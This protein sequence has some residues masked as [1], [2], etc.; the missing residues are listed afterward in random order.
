MKV[1]SIINTAIYKQNNTNIKNNKGNITFKSKLISLLNGKLEKFGDQ[2]V[3]IYEADKELREFPYD[4]FLYRQDESL[5]AD[6]RINIKGIIKDILTTKQLIDLDI[7]SPNSVI[8]M[9][10]LNHETANINMPPAA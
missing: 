9:L 2:I 8:P 5:I 7:H 6:T 3:K 1:D 10:R 4:T